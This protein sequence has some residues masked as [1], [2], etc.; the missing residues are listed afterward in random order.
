MAK[1]STDELA[2]RYALMKE[3]RDTFEAKC[4][5]LEEENNR[6]KS[7]QQT[8]PA[9][10]STPTHAEQRESALVTAFRDLKPDIIWLK[11][12]LDTLLKQMAAFVNTI[13]DLTKL[14]SE[15]FPI[16]ITEEDKQKLTQAV[17]D[18]CA[19][20]LAE[21]NRF[22]EENN[23][24]RISMSSLDFWS[25]IYLLI[26]LAM[27]FALTIAANAMI[28]HSD[29]LSKILWYISALIALPAIAVIIYRIKH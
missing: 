17:H 26:T 24:N 4:K 29:P 1:K 12:S 2:E 5:A 7:A 13:L 21:I 19:N 15:S 10:T 8:Q 25:M 14:L 20:Q 6:L 28:L 16:K 18:A 11:N 22:R 9:V 23:S 27:A 3:E